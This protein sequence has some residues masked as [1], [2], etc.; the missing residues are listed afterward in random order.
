METYSV[1]VGTEGEIILPCELRK[2]FGLVAEDTLDICVDSEGKVFVRT[3]ERSV[4]PLSDFFEDLIINDLL[5]KGCMGDCLKNK[6]LE[7]KLKLSAVLDRLSEDAYRAHRN[8]QSIRCWDNQTVASLGINNKDCHSVYKAMLTTRCVHDLAILKKEELR[9]IPTV[10]RCLEQDPYGHKRLRGPHYETFRISFRSG[11][12][13]YRV[14]YTVFAPENLIVVTM[15][16]VRKAI[17]ERLK[18]SVSF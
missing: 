7:R 14:I 11:S 2:L 8:G 5:A 3:A 10:F 17:Y 15:I 1:K 12:H 18:K 9:E 16:G 4:Q 6:L 13:E